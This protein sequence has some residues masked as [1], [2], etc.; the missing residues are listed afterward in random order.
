LATGTRDYRLGWRL[1]PMEPA[2]ALACTLSCALSF[3]LTATRRETDVAQ[4][5]HTVRFEVGARW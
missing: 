3:D 2:P 4:P 1:T 5:E